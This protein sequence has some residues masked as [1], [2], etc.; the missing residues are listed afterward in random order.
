MN[1]DK[2]ET[3][4]MLHVKT[5]KGNMI[6]NPLEVLYL[7]A[8][9]KH[10]IVYLNNMLCVETHHLLKWYEEKSHEPQFFRCHNSFMVN[11]FYIDYH[12]GY[13][14]FLTKKHINIPISR[15]KKRLYKNNLEFYKQNRFT[16]SVL[17]SISHKIQYAL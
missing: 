5:A 6:I 2:I 9:N 3:A 13:Q 16:H 4:P 7:E 17:N 14:I 11:C 15:S 12:F 8:K 1:P 10:T